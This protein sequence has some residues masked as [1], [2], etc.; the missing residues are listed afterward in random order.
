MKKI[1]HDRFKIKNNTRVIIDNS[2]K[3][4]KEKWIK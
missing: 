3:L 1:I 2:N 4:D